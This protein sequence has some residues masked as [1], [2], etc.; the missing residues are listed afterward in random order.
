VKIGKSKELHDN[1][2][3]WDN[4]YGSLEVNVRE[5]RASKF[6]ISNGEYLEFYK[7]GGYHDQKY[8][9]EEGW[10]WKIRENV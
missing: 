3:G 6:L 10:A 7:S 5:F 4:E 8:W 2:F 9:E 1:T